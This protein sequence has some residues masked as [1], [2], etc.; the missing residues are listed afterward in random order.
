M[1]GITCQECDTVYSLWVASTFNKMARN[2]TR[3]ADTV[4]VLDFETTGLSPDGGDRAIEI[5]AVRI[6]KGKIKDRFQSLMNPGKRVASFIE[7]Y[8]GITNA[9]LKTAPLCKTVM[10][11]FADFV[12]DFDMVAHNAS[13]DSRFLMAECRRIKRS[14]AGEFACSMLASRRL[15]PDAPNHKLGTLV[16]YHRLPSDGTFHRALADAEMT[17]HLWL[18]LLTDI[19]DN[20]RL[21]QIPF[22]LM[23]GIAKTPKAKLDQFLKDWRT[24]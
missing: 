1:F 24:N 5:G 10:S 2:T 20:Y 4:V 22:S 6:E 11:E 23:Q 17:A 16:D 7:E 8:T 15:Y 3:R 18:K 14:P 13:F 19:E 12:E 21:K 9:M